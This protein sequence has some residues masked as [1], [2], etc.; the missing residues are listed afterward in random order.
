MDLQ[1][2]GWG[3]TDCISLVQN[4]GRWRAFVNAVMN[5]RFHKMRENSGLPEDLLSSL[6][7]LCSKE[8]VSV[9]HL[10]Q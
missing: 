5:F 3:G 4:R 1:E 7:E 2:C 9:V 10:V 6:E 8:L